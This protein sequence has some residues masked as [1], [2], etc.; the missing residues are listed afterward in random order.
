MNR[1]PIME[2]VPQMSLGELWRLVPNY[3]GSALQSGQIEEITADELLTLFATLETLVKNDKRETVIELQRQLADCHTEFADFI[4]TE[5]N[6]DQSASIKKAI[7]CSEGG[8]KSG[9]NK[10]EW[11]DANDQKVREFYDQA[12][13]AIEAA[14]KTPSRRSLFKKAR[15]IAHPQLKSFV[16][17]RSVRRYLGSR[18]KRRSY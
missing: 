16:T 18:G 5:I 15:E 6:D 17:D 1:D 13:D 14:G 7:N 10:S 2:L 4:Q 11:A 9:E 8:K 3:I 12:Y